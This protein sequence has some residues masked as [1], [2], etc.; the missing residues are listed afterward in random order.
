MI[1]KSFSTQLR[2]NFP[3]DR[4]RLHRYCSNVQTVNSQQSTVNSQQSTVNRQPSTVNCQQSFLSAIELPVN[5][6]ST[7]FKLV[8]TPA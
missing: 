3:S 8:V 5:S 7:W 2:S 6:V 1:F 4:F